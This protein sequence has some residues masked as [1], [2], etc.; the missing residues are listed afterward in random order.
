MKRNRATIGAL[1]LVVLFFIPATSNAQIGEIIG[2]VIEAIDIGVQKAQNAVIDLQNVEK[3]I[4]NEL[5][6]TQ[7]AQI[8]D[9][10]QQQ[11]DLYSNYFTE[12]WKVKTVITDFRKITSI[13]ASQAQLVTEYKT[14]Y[15][16]VRRDPHFTPGEVNYIYNVLSSIVNESIQNIDQITKLLESFT[17]QMSDADRMRLIQHASDNIQREIGNLRAFNSQNAALSLQRATDQKDLN[18]VK[19]L[20]GLP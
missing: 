16:Q 5:S 9:W 14:A 2:A 8:A 7:L 20:Y 1:L 12:L 11:K 13:I 3:Q 19:Q 17:V 10:T 18:T 15:A 4:E 6:Q